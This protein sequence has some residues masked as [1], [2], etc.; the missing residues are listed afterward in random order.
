MRIT[1]QMA[2]KSFLRDLGRNQSYMKK[3]NDQ[4][5]S[6]KEI[7]RPSDDPFKVAR[8]M[9]LN[10]DIGA[11]TQ[12]NENIK[13]TT[14]WLET[15]DTALEQ[16]GNSLQRFRELMVSAG[17]AAYGS[18][19]KKAIKDEMNEKVN[20]ISQILNSS[21]DGKYIF[22][23]SKVSSKPVGSSK[24]IETGNN[25][26]N[27]SGKDGEVLKLD[28]LDENVQ[29]QINMINQKLNV[30]VS[31]GVTMEYSVSATDILMFKDKN[32]ASVNAME[33]LKDITDNVDSSNTDESSKITNEY[34]KTMDDT[35]TNL[36]RIRAEVGA[37]QNRM[38]SAENQNDEQN[39]NLKDILSQTEDIDFAEK[40]IEATVAQS[41]YSA[42]LQVSAKIIQP[43]LLDF[44]R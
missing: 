37:K 31:Q 12:Y 33:L 40:M 32:G 34:L 38:E 4:L 10:R 1:N 3:I 7:R 9:Q 28:N 8:S 26:I 24:D 36:L 44:L 19:E 29:N 11:N 15:T 16:L 18:D 27:L 25:Y 2:S 41:V 23:G 35:I 20:E 30:E 39:F 21:F 42:S 5:T 22:G 17:N 14:N 6:G 43:S 13:D